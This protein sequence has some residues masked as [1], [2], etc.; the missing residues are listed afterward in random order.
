M[1]FSGALPRRQI[2]SLN[3]LFQKNFKGKTDLQLQKESMLQMCSVHYKNYVN[4]VSKIS[5]VIP[6]KEQG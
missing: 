5:K 1:D 4:K 3:D 2:T 6:P